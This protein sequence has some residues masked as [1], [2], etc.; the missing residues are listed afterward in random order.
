MKYLAINVTVYVQHP[1]KENYKTLTKEMKEELNK[2]REIPCSWT[3]RLNIVQM[4]VLSRLIYRF[5]AIP[6][7]TPESYFVNTNNMVL[8]VY[9]GKKK[10]QNSQNNI[11]RDEKALRTD[12]T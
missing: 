10:M 5:C 7:E 2:W 11:E 6:K 9:M 8:T 12:T 3:G 4:S 1:W